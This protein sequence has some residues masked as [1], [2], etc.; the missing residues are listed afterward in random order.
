MRFII[1]FA[2]SLAFLSGCS[3]PVNVDTLIVRNGLSYSP[4]SLEPFSG[5]ALQV[6]FR[7]MESDTLRIEGKY[8]N[9]LRHGA[10][11]GHQPNG[12]VAE[13]SNYVNGQLHGKYLQYHKNGELVTMGSFDSGK[14]QGEWSYYFENG[15]LYSSGHFLNGD[16]SDTS[17][18]SGIPKNGRD[19]CWESF[20]PTGELFQEQH[21]T[22]GMLNG[23]CKVWYDTGQLENKYEFVNDELIGA[24][25]EYHKNGQKRREIA[26]DDSV[27]SHVTTWYQS[28]VIESRGRYV[29]GLHEGMFE[30]WYVN[31]QLREKGKMRGGVRVGEWTIWHESGAIANRGSYSN[32]KKVGLWEHWGRNGQILLTENFRNGVQNGLFI[33]RYSNGEIQHQGSMRD[34][35]RHGEWEY[36]GESGQFQGHKYY[37]DGVQIRI[38]ETEAEWSRIEEDRL[39]VIS[40]EDEQRI[41]II[42]NQLSR[43]NSLLDKCEKHFGMYSPYNTQDQ[44]DS[45]VGGLVSIRIRDHLE[46]V[47]GELTSDFLTNALPPQQSSR[48]SDTWDRMVRVAWQ[49]KNHTDRTF[50]PLQKEIWRY[51]EEWMKRMRRDMG[52]ETDSPLGERLKNWIESL[53][54]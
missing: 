34:G 8:L 54:D 26:F 49:W 5:K 37:D 10:W 20:H 46:T 39:Y 42:D 7:G 16:G 33:E 53:D 47:Y 12:Q 45:G 41:A 24:Y 11:I 13:I 23:V 14:M 35:K 38:E 2:A 25:E 21:Y 32:D 18:V 40:K 30:F 3:Q 52:L 6:L 19:G 44:N 1:V 9:G 4:G 27:T 50:M 15:Q 17:E 28:G 31:G 22:A 51:E 43:L 29:E 48:R 36:Y